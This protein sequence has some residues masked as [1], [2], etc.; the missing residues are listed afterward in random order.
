MSAASIAPLFSSA[1]ADQRRIAESYIAQLNQ[2]HAFARPITTR[3]EPLKGFYPAE[4]YHQDYL[5]HH[6]DALYIEYNDLPKVENLE[7]VFPA[8]YNPEPVLTSSK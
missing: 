5:V 3:I 2:A 4:G 8:L 1:D 7:R 6:P